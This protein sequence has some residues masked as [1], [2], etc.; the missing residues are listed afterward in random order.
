MK[1]T[2]TPLPKVLD[3]LKIDAKII[4]LNKSKQSEKL[5]PLIK[6]NN[7]EINNNFYGSVNLEAT[8]AL[9][10]KFTLTQ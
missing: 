6:N 3:D 8:N 5:K 7:F 4:D 9:N 1:H 10:G 2:K